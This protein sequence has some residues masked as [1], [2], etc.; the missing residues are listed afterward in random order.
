V[1]KSAHNPIQATAPANSSDFRAGAVM[2]PGSTFVLI[3]LV[4]VLPGLA[5][6]SKS[7]Y[8]QTPVFVTVIE[9]EQNVCN[10]NRASNVDGGAT[11]RHGADD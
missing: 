3:S 6:V 5:F 7:V 8:M 10:N 2:P 4:F 9:H 1:F 11:E